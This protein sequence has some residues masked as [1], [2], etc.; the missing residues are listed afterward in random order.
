LPKAAD[1]GEVYLGMMYE[2][3]RGTSANTS[4]AVK[5]YEASAAQHNQL[6]EYRLGQLYQNGSGVS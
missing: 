4:M 5:L 6:A 1:W 2:L 3:G